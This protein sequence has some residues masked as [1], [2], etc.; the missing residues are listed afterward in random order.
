MIWEYY[1]TVQFELKIETIWPLNI[2][3]LTFVAFYDTNS[4]NNYN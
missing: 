2:S 3:A 1:S 4:N